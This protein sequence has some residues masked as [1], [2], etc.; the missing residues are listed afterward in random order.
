MGVKMPEWDFFNA[1]KEAHRIVQDHVSGV[2]RDPRL[3]FFVYS[4]PLV[5]T[6]DF[7]P[8]MNFRIKIDEEFD[9]QGYIDGLNIGTSQSLEIK[10]GAPWSMT[11]FQKSFQRK[12]YSLLLPEIKEQLL[13]SISANPDEWNSS[14][15]KVFSASPTKTDRDEAMEWIKGGIKI[16]KEGDFYRDLVKHEDGSW[17]CE[18][19]RCLYGDKCFF[20]HGTNL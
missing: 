16:F 12:V 19:P 17:H 8:K 4:F 18:D 11:K 13:L 1:G 6:V 20:K 2:I 3:S 9:V 14:T 5:E 10:T 7:D 15:S